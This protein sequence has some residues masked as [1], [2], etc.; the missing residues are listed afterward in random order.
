MEDSKIIE[1]FFERSEQAIIELS[2]KYEKLCKRVAGNITGNELDAEECVNDAFIGVWNSIPPQNPDSLIGF[3]C[4]I[5]RNLAI[6]KLRGNTAAKRSSSYDVSLEELAECLPNGS[7]V[8]DEY[9]A[10]EIAEEIER[11][12]YGCKPKDRVMFV[13][14]YFFSDSITDIAN[15]FGVSEHYVSVRLHRTKA[16]LRKHLLKEGVYI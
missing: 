12:L 4:R 6:K 15:L 3:V 11:F 7:C 9:D 8:E 1:L 2:K 5:T 14:R 16:E 10:K 13:R